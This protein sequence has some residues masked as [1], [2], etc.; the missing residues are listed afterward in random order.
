MILVRR[1]VVAY[2]VLGS[3]GIVSEVTGS[4]ISM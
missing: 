4:V 2:A 3:V 1:E